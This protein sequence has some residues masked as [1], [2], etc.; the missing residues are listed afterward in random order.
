MA[1]IFFVTDPLSLLVTIL[2]LRGLILYFLSMMVALMMHMSLL[3]EAF[4]DKNG[5]IFGFNY[6]H[7]LFDL[8]ESDL[9]HFFFIELWQII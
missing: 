4:L 3:V 8:I 9:L 1:Q 2:I 6:A 5:F 7:E